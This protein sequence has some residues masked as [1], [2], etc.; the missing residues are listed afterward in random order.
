M[1]SKAKSLIFIGIFVICMALVFLILVLT[2]PRA[3]GND[4][5]D[6]S[7]SNTTVALTNYERDNIST[8]KIKNSTGE[9]TITQT[10]LGFSVDELKDL[11]QNTTTM[12]A[13]GNCVA[14]ITAQTLVEENA[15]D[16]AKYGLEA[17]SPEAEC[18]VTLKDGS[19]YT[20]LYGVTAPDGSS[21]YV[22]LADSNDVYVVLLNSSRYFYNSK[23][24]YISLIIKEQLSNDNTAPTI[25]LLTV[26]RKDLD[27]DIVFED[28]TKNYSVDEVSMASSQ[29]MISPV[30]AY[31]DITNSNDIIYGIWGLTAT[32][33]VKPF[34][35]EEDM[36]EYGLADPFCTVTIN[37]ELQTY[38]L[39]IGNIAS[40]VI[41]EDGNPTT[42]PESY[43][44]YFEGKDVI[45][46]FSAT[47]VK[48]ATFMPGDILSSMMTSNYIYALDY[49]DIELHNG[50]E[51][52]Y[53]YDIEGS[54]DDASLAVSL[55]DKY[56]DADDFKILYQFV[57]K[58]PIDDLCLEDPKEDAKLLAYIDFARAEGGG[59]TLEFYDDGANRVII[60]LNGV[61]SFSQPK[62]YL[63]TLTS[64]L[65]LF[66]EGRPTEDLQ[67]IW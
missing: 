13:A 12:G 66:A 42:E 47:E 59:D 53:H 17:D 29:V 11:K 63:D 26:T 6:Q 48:W 9:Y 33:A 24:S 58:C 14:K 43:Y 18:V 45:Y 19:S 57:L 55:N 67:M 30:Y 46:I 7:E 25:D 22:R 4:K 16:L 54:V 2:Q 65:K 32:E 31:L 56:V 49:M 52:S 15:Q 61:T 34:P 60:K 28:D 20:V 23:E 1:K 39:S 40:Y 5:D 21:V 37:A 41:G 8:M 38:K 62:S 3:E 27:Y 35:T 51:I 10:A 64:N 50:E 36:A 44:G